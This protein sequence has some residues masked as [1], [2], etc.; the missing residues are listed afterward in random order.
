M[1]IYLLPVA[2]R[3]ICLTIATLGT[4][5]AG[6]GAAL[7]ATAWTWWL[8][9]LIIFGSFTLLGIHDVIQQRHSIL[10]NYPIAAHLRFLLEHVRPEM[11]QYFF[12]DE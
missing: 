11:R 10:R 3:F 12:E 8:P 6:L 9:I 4:L 5:G 1:H 7:Q 2:P